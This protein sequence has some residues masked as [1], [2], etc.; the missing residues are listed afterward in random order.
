MSYGKVKVGPV[1]EGETWFAWEAGQMLAYGE[2]C[3]FYV[4]ECEAGKFALKTDPPKKIKGCFTLFCGKGPYRT[5]AYVNQYLVPAE[6]EVCIEV[7]VCPTTG[8]PPNIVDLDRPCGGCIFVGWN[9]KPVCAEAGSPVLLGQAPEGN[10]SPRYINGRHCVDP[11]EKI[12]VKNPTGA[13]IIVNAGF[14]L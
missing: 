5:D 7:P 2:G 13:A 12:W 11:V 4:P 6:G 3:E 1:P 8:N 10:P 9:K 14:F